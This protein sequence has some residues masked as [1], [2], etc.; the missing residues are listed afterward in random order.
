MWLQIAVME[1]DRLLFRVRQVERA[2][3]FDVVDMPLVSVIPRHSRQKFR[4][5]MA[6][7]L[8]H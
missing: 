2:Q 4:F 5:Q 1:S 7:K 8:G 6:H 3:R